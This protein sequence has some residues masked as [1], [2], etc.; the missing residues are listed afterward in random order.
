MFIQSIKRY[1]HQHCMTIKWAD[2]K[3]YLRV[4]L[5]VQMQKKN[6]IYR[7]IDKSPDRMV[8][9]RLKIAA[10]YPCIILLDCFIVHYF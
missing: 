8:K 9:I 4:W 5:H 1:S 6:G 3:L 2:E 10:M 7:E